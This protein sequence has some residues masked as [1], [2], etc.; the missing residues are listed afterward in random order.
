MSIINNTPI[1][2]AVC[3]NVEEYPVVISTH[4]FGHMDLDT[5]PPEDMRSFLA[6]NIQQCPHCGYTHDT[7]SEKL[8]PDV[9]EWIKLPEY[10]D[11]L[12]DGKTPFL[13]GTYSLS[14]RLY[15]K[16][17]D[18][19]SAGIQSLRAAWACDDLKS[20]EKAIQFRKEALSYLYTYVDQTQDLHIAVLEVDLLRRT[21]DF[22]SAKEFASLLL[23]LDLEEI[24]RNVLLF[25]LRLIDAKDNKC[26]SL[27]E[28]DD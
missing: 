1:R 11:K 19:R 28:I 13:A 27:G 6:Y 20:P 14:A 17:G 25:E 16:S 5:R 21:D 12:N 8:H 26:H 24:L 9:A 18:L 7:V 23:E 4:S 15:A 3:G 2:C 22:D 10:T